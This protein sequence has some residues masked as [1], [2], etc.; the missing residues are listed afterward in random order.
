MGS[1]RSTKSYI[2][3]ESSH[4]FR[5]GE[6]FSTQIFVCDVC[7]YL[8]REVYGFDDYHAIV[9]FGSTKEDQAD[10][11]TRSLERQ[12]VEVMRMNPL[13]S[14][15]DNDKSFYKPAFYIHR[16]MNEI[17]KGSEVVLVGFHNHRYEEILTKY[18]EGYKLHVAA[19]STRTTSGDWMRIPEHWSQMCM[20]VTEL[21]SRVDLIKEEFYRSKRT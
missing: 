20:S 9:L 8:A 3:I 21:D 11:Y 13:Q 5:A 17:P 7:K 15:V 10:R 6:K 12:G 2:I 19:F 16:I 1:N 18:G 4:L 14:R